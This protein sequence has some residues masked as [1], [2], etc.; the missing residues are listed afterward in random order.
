MKVQGGATFS[1]C[2]KYRYALVRWWDEGY[3][4]DARTINF[5]C[6]NPSTATAEVSD[7]TVTRLVA[8]AKDLGFERLIVTNIFAWRS[9]GPNALLKL[10]DGIGPDNDA[11]L[12]NTARNSQMVVCGWSSHRAA[13]WRGPAVKLMLLKCNIPLH[14][15]DLSE[16]GQPKHPLYL[17]YKL[18]PVP[19]R[20][21]A[22][23][24]ATVSLHSG[25]GEGKS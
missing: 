5:I 18:K 24:Q 16:S 14:V 2:E 21:A 19:W 15:L 6:L 12:V 11:T 4:L 8:R 10:S 13:K 3:R 1:P 25:G 17:S 22:R 20:D 7:P 23:E 9:T